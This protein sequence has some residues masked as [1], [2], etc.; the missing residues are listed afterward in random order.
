MSK[1]LLRMIRALIKAPG[2]AMNPDAFFNVFIF[3]KSC[4]ISVFGTLNLHQNLHHLCV[5]L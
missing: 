5:E 3:A 1:P 4:H 2:F